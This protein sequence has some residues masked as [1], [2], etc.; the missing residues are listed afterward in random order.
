MFKKVLF[1]AAV[2]SLTFGQSIEDRVEALEYAGYEN[3]FKFGGSLEYRFDSVEREAKKAYTT[4]TFAGDTVSVAQGQKDSVKHHKLY[5]ELDISAQP[6]DKLS[7]YGRLATSKYFNT[8]NKGGGDYASEAAFGELSEGQGDDNSRV[9]LERAF[10]NYNLMKSLTLSVGR[11]PTIDGAPK[12]MAQG[13]PM[14]GNYPNLAFAGVFDGM[15]LTYAKN[16]GANMFKLKAIYTPFN[17]RN[18]GVPSEKLTDNNGFEVDE[19]VDVYSAL[20]EYERQNLSWAKKVHFIYQYLKF[21]G[22][23]AISSGAA[24]ITD[25]MVAGGGSGQNGVIEKRTTLSDAQ[26]GLE[27]HILNLEMYGLF[28]TGLNFG[29]SY[30]TGNTKGSGAYSV[31]VDS[32]DVGGTNTTTVGTWYGS[33]NVDKDG[34]AWIMNLSYNIAQ[35]NNAIFGFEYMD[36]EPDAFL[37]DSA[38]KNQA[39]FYTARG[40]S[41]MHFY[42]V[43]PV[44]RNFKIQLGYQEVNSKKTNLVGGYIGSDVPLDNT[45][46]AYYS[47]FQ[48]FF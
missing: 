22:L 11:L 32:A 5:A 39:G 37:Y 20:L 38:A 19:S 28:N 40:D 18:V 2:A 34:S 36:S 4:N 17:Q 23:Y 9:F 21:D 44:D 12:H 10:V 13:R 16:I 25:N 27:R 8:L 15:A 35:L 24:T 41:S 45:T 42:W 7:F 43:Q 33:G 3:W 29:F 1:T 31:K 30:M 26:L 46:K 6:S 47:S 48:F 14:M